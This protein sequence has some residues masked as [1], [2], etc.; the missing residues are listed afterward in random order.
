MTAMRCSNCN[1]REIGLLPVYKPGS[2]T[3]IY[4]CGACAEAAG[5]ILSDA[6]PVFGPQPAPE[7]VEANRAAMKALRNDWK[8]RSAEIHDLAAKKRAKEEWERRQGL[9]SS[10]I[11]QGALF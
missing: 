4:V 11:D 8:A 2:R 5:A 7:V 1:V 6:R 3:R 9:P 10:E